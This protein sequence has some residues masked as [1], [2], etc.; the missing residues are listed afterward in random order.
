VVSLSKRAKD[1]FWKNY[2]VGRNW[3]KSLGDDRRSARDLG[4]EARSRFQ[5]IRETDEYQA[6]YDR[7]EPL[8]SI[9][10]ATYNRADLLRQRSLRSAM[11]QSYSNIEI[12]VVGDCCTDHTE[13]VM[14]DV[15]DPRVVFTNLPKRADYPT[16][17]LLRWMVAGTAAINHCLSLAQGDFVTHLDDDDEHSPDRVEKLVSCIREARTDLLY[18]P[19][20]YETPEGWHI[21][22]A[23]RFGFGR[24][25]TSSIF[26]HRWFAGLRWDPLAYR[27][28]EPADWNRLRKIKYL[29][30]HFARHPGIFLTHY[31]ERN[32][33]G[34]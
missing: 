31:R 14:R 28:R 16:E 11:E 4:P 8:V 18:H 30:A 29:G 22:K 6:V 19:F 3:L 32:Q 23:R 7:P 15:R 12:L 33:E 1:A 21:N 2:W 5:S 9:C 17:P 10:I 24:A 13:T 27:Y 25:T 34:S 26:Y 20:R